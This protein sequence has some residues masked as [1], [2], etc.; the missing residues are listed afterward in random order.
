MSSLNLP[1]YLTAKEFSLLELFVKNKNIALFREMLYQK[2]WGY[3]YDVDSRTV[4]L[5]VQRL[6]K[7]L[8]LEKSLITVHKIGY[9]LEVPN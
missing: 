8:G 7:K 9:R 4:D 3:E 5:H 6:R 2:V 1:V